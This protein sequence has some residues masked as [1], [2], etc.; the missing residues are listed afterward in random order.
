MVGAELDDRL[1]NLRQ[2]AG[3]PQML[4]ARTPRSAASLRPGWLAALHLMGPENQLLV[5]SPVG[6]A[7]KGGNRRPCS[8][9]SQLSR[10]PGRR[11]MKAMN[12]GLYQAS[13][14]VGAGG[15]GRDGEQVSTNRLAVDLVSE[16]G[17]SVTFMGEIIA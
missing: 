14:A 4:F 16:E 13:T 9:H 11:L 7:R 2:P 12:P 10:A 17:P 15:L 8:L 1:E 6:S 3:F 5:R